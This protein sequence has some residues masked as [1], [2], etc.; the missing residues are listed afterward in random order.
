MIYCIISCF[1]FKY[2]YINKDLPSWFDF[3]TH[4]ALSTL[5]TYPNSF[6]FR[7]KALIES[8]MR[9]YLFIFFS[10]HLLL[11]FHFPAPILFSGA[12]TLALSKCWR[13]SS[14]SLETEVPGWG[15]VVISHHGALCGMLVLSE[16]WRQQRTTHT[17]TL[18][19]GSCVW[20]L[21]T[22]LFA[23]VLLSP[24]FWSSPTGLWAFFCRK[25]FQLTWFDKN[26]VF[27]LCIIVYVSHP[28]TQNTHR[29]SNI[30]CFPLVQCKTILH[31]N[32]STCWCI[33]SMTSMQHCPG[34]DLQIHLFA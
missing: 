8:L 34:S 14:E 10:K 16:W 33:N 32:S 18:R 4:D 12:P 6:P 3:K 24:H 13:H 2:Y 29:L 23:D 11:A 25:T 26:G 9:N 21:V 15:A 17:T 30:L 19:R 20:V 28:H 31:C 7:Q 27:A 5:N 22:L 1:D